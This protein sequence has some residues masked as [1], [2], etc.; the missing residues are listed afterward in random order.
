M[1]IDQFLPGFGSGDAISNYALALRDII[2]S[3]GC[4]S[5]IY[6]VRRHVT[7]LVEELCEDY[8]DFPSP[9]SPDDVV[10]YHYSIGSELSLFVSGLAGKKVLVYHNI[11]PCGYFAG[12]HEEKM[13]ALWEGREELK[14]MA[15]AVDLALGVSE[16][17]RREL[18]ECGFGRTGVL[19]LILDRKRL[20]SIAPDGALMRRYGDG[21]TNILFVGRMAPNKRIE[22]LIK[23]FHYYQRTIDREA[24]LLLAGSAIGM[25]RYVS[26]L[27]MLVSTL[28]LPGVE[29]LDH[30]TDPEL[31]ALYRRACVYLCMSEHEG[32]CIPLLEAMHFGV[33]VVAYAAAAVPETLGGAGV[34]VREKDPAAVAEMVRALD[35]DG[36]LRHAVVKRQFARLGAF[37]PEAVAERLRGHLA[38][39]LG[40]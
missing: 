3:W 36:P 29:F 24:R 7:S 28:D 5:R 38:P 14:G 32:F 8:R 2:R 19:P 16:F 35:E 1:R 22:D 30:V 26:H 37:S 10:L 12:I 15:G 31:Y 11:T 4:D 34:L 25:D 17:N 20:S 40:Q 18:E 21:R 27:R 9:G 33:P 39:W 13:K 6:S 23:V